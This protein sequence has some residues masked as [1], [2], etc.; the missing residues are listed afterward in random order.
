MAIA[1]FRG[2]RSHLNGPI[3]LAVIK[4]YHSILK[5]LEEATGEFLLDYSIPP[6]SIASRPLNYSRA[7]GAPQLSREMYCD[8]AVFKAIIDALGSRL[9]C[10]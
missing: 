10:G 8:K 4:E 2:F 9:K 3:T 1:R 6:G 7:N 5:E